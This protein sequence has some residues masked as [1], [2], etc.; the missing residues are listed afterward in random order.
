MQFVICCK[1]TSGVKKSL[2]RYALGILKP[3]IPAE[4][5]SC[6]MASSVPGALRIPTYLLSL[7]PFS[8]V[9]CVLATSLKTKV[10][11]ATLSH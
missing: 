9:P 4:M 2:E 7:H 6:I 10:L 8:H 5:D 3:V 11:K 1:H